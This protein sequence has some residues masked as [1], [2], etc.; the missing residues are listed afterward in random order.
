M[1]TDW[2]IFSLCS[3]ILIQFSFF[4]FCFS[5]STTVCCGPWL[6][7]QPC[8]F[9]PAFGHCMPVSYSHYLQILFNLISP[10]FLWPSSFPYSFRSG[11]QYLFWHS[12]IILPFTMSI[13]SS[14]KWLCEFYNPCPL[15]CILYPLTSFSPTFFF[16]YG[17]I[18]FSYNLPHS[19]W[20][21]C[22]ASVP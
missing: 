9:L 12:F 2:H 8:P 17:T 18:Y 21:H 19:F 1:C 15:W 4:F 22:P 13:P 7:I 5:S 10:S 14:S 11:I 20:V 3:F 6:A 16:F